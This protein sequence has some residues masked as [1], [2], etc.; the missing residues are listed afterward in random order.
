MVSRG[1]VSTVVFLC[2][3]KEESDNGGVVGDELTIEVGKAKEGSYF[4][5]FGG[6]WPGSNA[7][8]LYRVYNELS[9][10]DNHPEVF[11]FGDVKL[12]LLKLEVEVKLSHVLKNAASSFSMGL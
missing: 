4:L 8:K 1:P 12:A 2:E 7:I 5:D 11:H 10:F 9:W 3:V 6:G